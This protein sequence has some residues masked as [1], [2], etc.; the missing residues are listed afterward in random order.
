[1]KIKKIWK[2][3]KE[4]RRLRRKVKVLEA[5]L[6]SANMRY[7]T[8]FYTKSKEVPYNT[9]SIMIPNMYHIEAVCGNRDM[10]SRPRAGYIHKRMTEQMK[11]KLVND[12]AEQGYIRLVEDNEIG[13]IYEIKVVR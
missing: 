1:M 10:Y 5:D 4:L 8:L 13:E 6:H 7:N 9:M 12:L 11:I 2:L 3:Y